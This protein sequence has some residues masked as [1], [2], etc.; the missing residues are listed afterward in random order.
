MNDLI[1]YCAIGIVIL[2]ALDE[3]W[4]DPIEN[5]DDESIIKR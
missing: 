1:F 3:V 2:L 4:K 5:D